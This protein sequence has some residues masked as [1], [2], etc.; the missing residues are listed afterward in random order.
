[1]QISSFGDAR[2]LDESDPLREFRDCFDL[3]EGVLYFD[4]NSLGAVPRE[5]APRLTD[6]IVREWGRGLVRSWNG[7]WFDAATRVGDKIAQLIGAQSGEVIVADSTTINVCKLVYA[8]LAARPGRST[9]LSEPGNFPTDLYAVQGVIRSLGGRHALQLVEIG[10]LT[11]SINDDTALVLLTHIHY[12]TAAI[13]DMR[14]ITSKAH[15]HGA[16]VLW[17]LSHSAGAVEVDLNGAGADLAIGC[18]YKYLNGGP[19]APAFLFVAHRHQTSLDAVLAGW[20][21]HAAPFEFSDEYV[22][23]QSIRRFTSGTPPILAIAALEVGVD[24]HLRAG[25]R[26]LAAKSRALSEC[27]MGVVGP[28]CAEHGLSISSPRASEE[29]GSH[30]AITGPDGLRIMRAL[31]ERGVI[32]D[33]RAPDTLRFGFAPIYTRYQDVWLAAEI[34]REVLETGAWR[35]E[36]HFQRGRV[37]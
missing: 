37:T 18:G 15:E 19:G 8:A 1:M 30:V 3:P 13:R 25:I 12:K 24:I 36:R 27:F 34:F 35:A 6:L 5:V 16:L 31:I 26:P 14:A 9:V 21:G 32:G 29:R 10:E 20:M 17:D 11:D 33:F 23:A 4:G 2:Q 22:P 28:F 7:E